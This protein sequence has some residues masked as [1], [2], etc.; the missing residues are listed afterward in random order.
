MKPISGLHRHHMYV[1]Q[2][3]THRK[4][5]HTLNENK[6][7][8]KNRHTYTYIK[9]EDFIFFSIVFRSENYYFLKLALNLHRSLRMSVIFDF[10]MWCQLETG[11]FAYWVTAPVLACIAAGLHLR[12]STPL[13]KTELENWMWRLVQVYNSGRRKQVGQTFN[14]IF[15]LTLQV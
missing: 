7:I 8:F 9:R 4:N 13:L 5:T 14:A 1:I 11:P 10:S 3:Y 6:H 2:R 15:S 12:S